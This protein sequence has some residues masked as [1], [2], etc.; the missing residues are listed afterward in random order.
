[1]IQKQ[2]A[3]L[4]AAI[5]AAAALSW[6]QPA[7]GAA[8]VTEQIVKVPV[9]VKDALWKVIEQDIT[10][11]VFEAPG[12]ATHPLLIL[13]HGRPTNTEGRMK[14]GRVRYSEAATWF[15]SLGFSVWVP[16]RIG[17]GVSG[18][19]EDPEYTGS[20][21]QRRYKPGFDAAA[22]QVVQVIEH[23]RRSAYID[24]SRIVVA[25]QSFGGATS[26]TVASR[27]PAGVVA[28]INFAGGS[29]GDPVARPGEPCLPQLLADTFKDFG[30]TA[31]VPT[32]WIYTENDLYFHPRHTRAWFEAYKSQG[33]AGE[34]V[35]LQPFGTDGHQLFTRGFTT[36]QP[37]VQ[38][39]LGQL[40]FNEI[41]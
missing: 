9:K 34:F 4:V 22:D 13:N 16:T 33:G 3:G 27:A 28:T 7:H 32:L 14:M 23:A 24:T 31:R 17:Y 1:M 5:C 35:L 41:K 39:F 12:R 26:I 40:G 19:D 18:T 10:V 37:I 36:W 20:C 38:K 6:L 15:A 8:P 25:G 21:T 2:T 11:T 29:G 30:K